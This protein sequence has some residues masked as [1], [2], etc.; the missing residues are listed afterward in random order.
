MLNR[1]I[2]SAFVLCACVATAA[3]AQT[4]TILFNSFVPPQHPINSRVF[5]EWVADVENATNGRVKIDVPPASLASPAQQ[6]DGVTKGI[7]DMAYMFH[8]LLENKVTLSQVAHL[9]GVN[10]TSKGSSIALWRTYEKYFKVAN[11][12]KDVHLLGLFVIYP[13][14]I[15]G[16]KKPVNSIADIKGLKILGNPGVPARL[17]EAAGAGVVAAPAVRSFEII[18]AGTV[19]AFAGY[20]P[21]DAF[22]FKTLQYAKYITDIPGGISAPSFALFMNKKKWDSLPQ[23]DQEAITKLSGEA[24]A[25]RFGAVDAVDNKVRAD[26]AAQGIEIKPASASFAAEM[27]KLSEPIIQ[28]WVKQANAAGID[29]AAA[30]AYYKQQAE[31]SAK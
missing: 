6:M 26:A 16:I 9:P 14:T 2:I 18:S 3:H 5:K 8:G 28:D 23:P 15:F 30:L 13:G 27:A 17:L 22:S 4:S 19:D 7:F 20:A 12:Y 11:E 25:A 1:R 24:L 10:T 21:A 29:G 31:L